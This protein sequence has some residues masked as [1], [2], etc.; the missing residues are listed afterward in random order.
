MILER[1]VRDE[2]QTHRDEDRPTPSDLVSAHGNVS[3]MDKKSLDRPPSSDPDEARGKRLRMVYM[4]VLT[5]AALALSF[6][7]NFL[8]LPVLPGAKLGL[9][10]IVTVVALV[11]LPRARDAA[12]VS[13]LRVV[14]GGIFAGGASFFYSA[15][16]AAFSF[17]VMALLFRTKIFHI[18]A[19]SAAGGFFH[20]VGELAVAYLFLGS[21]KALIHLLPPL[22]FI[23]VATGILIG[24]AASAAIDRIHFAMAHEV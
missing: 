5:A 12:L 1:R 23:G 24:L 15:A 9:A 13:F 14:L 8:P 6:V 7:E 10:N 20:N 4:G 19:V 16:G 17:V 22:G 21:P 2:D 18:A 11:T 3:T